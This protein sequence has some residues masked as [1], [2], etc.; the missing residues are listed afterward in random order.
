MTS[1]W[2]A[3]RLLNRAVGVATALLLGCSAAQTGA[4]VVP[5]TAKLGVV[6]CYV[7]LVRPGTGDSAGTASST[8]PARV[9]FTEQAQPP[10]R[11]TDPPA[12]RVRSLDPHVPTPP[13]AH[14]SPTTAPDTVGLWWWDGFAGWAG[15]VAVGR[16]SITGVLR[17][18]SDLDGPARSLEIS[19]ERERC[20]L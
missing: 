8:F 18:I 12:W 3:S 2:L 10:G 15:P 19:G 1:A 4:A 13:L 11:T 20:P 16:D 14:W 9:R 5:S 17:W 7:I 6:G